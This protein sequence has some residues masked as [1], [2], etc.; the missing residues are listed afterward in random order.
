MTD[1]LTPGDLARMARRTLLLQ[2]TFNYERQQG[3]GWAWAMEPAL[4]RFY[5]DPAARRA[6]LADHTA[7]FNTQPTLASLALGAV[8]GLEEARAEVGAPGADG[9]A[10]ARDVLGASLAALGDRLYWFTLRPFAAC[11]GVLL[12][13]VHGAWGAWALWLSYN[14]LHLGVRFGGV[15][16]GYRAGPSVM[17][18]ALR[19]R[20][21]TLVTALCV[22][23]CITIGAVVAWLLVPYGQPRPLAWQAALAAG[24]GVGLV[25]AQRPRP[26]PTEWAIGAGV[27]CLAAVWRA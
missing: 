23:G 11:L 15:A 16:W 20:I 18:D 2:A 26:S 24:M 13:M 25:A 9:I 3:L 27:L 14:V 10:R 17:G 1:R 19:R 21:T 8:A 6:R 4:E 12:A 5:P 22:L 7:Y